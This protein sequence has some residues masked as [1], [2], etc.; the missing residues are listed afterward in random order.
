MSNANNDITGRPPGWPQIPD[1][2]NESSDPDA[3]YSTEPLVLPPPK[4]NKLFGY[5]LGGGVVLAVFVLGAA[6][7]LPSMCMVRYSAARVHSMNNLKQM[8]IALNNSASATENGEIPPAYGT[9]PPNSETSQSF[10]VSLLPYIDQGNLYLTAANRNIPVKT[11]IA[12]GDP[13]NPGTSGLISYGSNATLLTVDGAPTFPGSFGGRTSGVIVVFERTAKSGATWN[14]KASYLF[15]HN[16]S[17]SPEFSTPPNWSSV[18]TRATA[19]TSAGCL[20]GMG[21]GSARVVT[22][23]NADAGWAWAMD[24]SIGPSTTPNGW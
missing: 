13:F 20:V 17:S 19:L 2:T 8:G 23:S 7:L 12:Q 22:Q 3:R 21:D 14:N 10:F 4:G 15:D 6:M 1:L 24:P 9:F 5:L 18:D 16:G 11:Y